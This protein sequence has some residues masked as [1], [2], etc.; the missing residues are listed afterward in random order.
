LVANAQGSFRVRSD[1]FIQ[2]GYDQYN[3]LSFGESSNGD[4]AI[5]HWNNGLNFLSHIRVQHM[6]TTN[7]LLK[8]TMD[9]LE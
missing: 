1:E 6:A 4:W 9:M 2:I 8:I 7:S 3:I 5:E